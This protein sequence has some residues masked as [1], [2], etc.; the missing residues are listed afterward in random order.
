[1]VRR[2]KNNINPVVLPLHPHAHLHTSTYINGTNI[3]VVEPVVDYDQSE[4]EDNVIKEN[5]KNDNR[6]S[7]IHNVNK[8]SSK[9]LELSSQQAV[10]VATPAAA[11]IMRRQ[12][13][14]KLVIARPI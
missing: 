12:G 6:R 14:E 1:M 2:S 10:F 11:A 7:S 13:S 9:L 5:L 3:G 8:G 4:N